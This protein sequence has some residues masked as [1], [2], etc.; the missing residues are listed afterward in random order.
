[1]DIGVVGCGYWGSKHL[2]VLHALH[3]VDTVVAIDSSEDR[4]REAQ[5]SMPGLASARTLEEVVGDLDGVV[6]A[7]PPRTHTGLAS[8]AIQA[9]TGV[10][11]EKPLTTNASE[12]RML[13]DEAEARGV[14][15]MVGHTFEHNAAVWKLRE[16]VE[17]DELGRLYYMDSARLNL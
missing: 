10:L 1:M 3:H 11:V 17:S 5:R 8:T 16:L 9:G 12:A 14:P 13:V 6:I 2:R 7:T 4:L 15:L